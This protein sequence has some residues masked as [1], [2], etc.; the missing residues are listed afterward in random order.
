MLAYKNNNFKINIIIINLLI[1]LIFPFNIANFDGYS[2]DQNTFL[3]LLIISITSSIIFIVLLFII[4][5]T[6]SKLNQNISFYIEIFIKFTLFW[7]FITGIFFPVTGDHDPF[8][9]VSLSIGKKYEILLKFVLAS[10]IFYIFEKNNL[11][12]LIFR[13]IIIYVIINLFFVVSQ[14]NFNFNDKHLIN[15]K[16]NKFGK[17]NLIVL[18]FDGISGIKMFDE[19]E[20]NQELRENLK[21][22]IFFKNVTTAFHIRMDRLM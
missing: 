17:K 8:L 5:K 11:T 15:T 13:F 9:N 21:D 4:K 12:N 19:V 3:S 20:D 14:I 18:S 7:V 10:I 22:F 16:I 1:F 6:L 2:Y